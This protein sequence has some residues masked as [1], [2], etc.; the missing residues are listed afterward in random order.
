MKVPR[1]VQYGLFIHK[2]VDELRRQID[3]PLKSIIIRLG[4]QNYE[5]SRDIQ[6]DGQSQ[7][8][9]IKGLA[10]SL[11]DLHLGFTNFSKAPD[12]TQTARM[13]TEVTNWLRPLAFDDV[14]DRYLSSLAPGS[15]QW[16]INKDQFQGW[17][18]APKINQRYPLLWITGPA[19]SGKTRLATKAIQTLRGNRQTAF[20]Y[21]D[22]QDSKKRS[23]IS[24]LRNWCW[25]LL[26]QDHSRLPEVNQVTFKH[27]IASQTALEGV[28]KTLLKGAA[29]PVLVIDAFD[30]CETREQSEFYRKLSGISELAR[31]LVFSRPL[32]DSFFKLQKAA[33]DNL[34][35]LKIS[36]S[37]TLSDINHYIENE[38]AEL[39]VEDDD[40]AAKIV[41]TLQSNAKGMFLWVA[42]MIN[43]LEKPRFDELE[44]LDTMAHLPKDLDDL[45]GRILENLSHSPQNRA[46]SRK[47]L[48]WILFSSRPLSLQEVGAAMMITP[49]EQRLRKASISEERVQKTIVQHC[50]SLV[51]IHQS[52]D[53]ESIVTLVHYSLKEYFLGDQTRNGNAVIFSFLPEDA[54]SVLGKVCL[55]YLCYDGIDGPPFDVE[56]S[57]ADDISLGE[58]ARRFN[59]Y[60]PRY[61]LLKY[62]ARHWWGHVIQSSFDSEV[63]EALE[64]FCTSSKWTIR[65]LQIIGRN[66][67]FMCAERSMKDLL[68][69][70]AI[71]ELLPPSDRFFKDWL[72]P[73]ERPQTFRLSLNRWQKYM[74]GLECLPGIH[75]AAFFDMHEV[76]EQYLESGFDVNHRSFHQQTPLYAAVQG[77]S[78]TTMKLLL[79]RGADV[80]ATDC[81]DD[82]PL[83]ASVGNFRWRLLHPVPYTSSHILLEAGADPSYGSGK[84]FTHLLEVCPPWDPY[85]LVLASEMLY[86][87][88]AA[89]INQGHPITPLQ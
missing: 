39:G 52:N 34:T 69:I 72:K 8:A 28:L 21:C 54:H 68:G 32:E 84:M 38:V 36:E 7:K 19:G 45:Y 4:I 89:T 27:Q 56:D 18:V 50:G 26:F 62:A 20:F 6:R 59:A 74:V 40:I 3:V 30:E 25:Q 11:D 67:G 10:N 66:Y 87:G 16:M 49:G 14:Y 44:Y 33:P 22:A 60:L 17:M 70:S 58:M 77:C 80:D 82:T 63:Y 41:S 43:E 48:Q 12:P 76:V 46:L 73:F 79:A 81:W 23:V 85:C 31:I 13:F 71:G 37:D 29:D 47:I 88:A 1:K 24:I 15:C 83:R 78:Y 9:L 75:V 2:E 64:T 53:G 65:W 5:I 35:L 86:K 57:E 61:P 51:T 42:L 55:T